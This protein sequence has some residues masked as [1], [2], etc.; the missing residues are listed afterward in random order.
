MVGG[1]LFYKNIFESVETVPETWDESETT[2][3]ALDAK[4]ELDILAEELYTLLRNNLSKLYQSAPSPLSTV[5]KSTEKSSYLD[6]LAK[7]VVSDTFNVAGFHESFLLTLLRAKTHYEPA[8]A[9]KSKSLG[10]LR[11]ELGSVENRLSFVQR[12]NERGQASHDELYFLQQKIG[13]LRVAISRKEIGKTTRVKVSSE[14]QLVSRGLKYLSESKYKMNVLMEKV[15]AIGSAKRVET[16]PT[17]VTLVAYKQQLAQA[18]ER[19]ERERAAAALAV[20][21]AAA[22]PK[23]PESDVFVKVVKK[24]T[25][26]TSGLSRTQLLRAALARK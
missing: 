4:T 22:A 23:K 13:V 2:S 8:A 6:W 26:T 9:A 24:T 21:Q 17:S 7:N 25:S 10:D 3:E 14:Y 16:A 1:V 12:M 5:A 11:A 15:R 18:A 20:A 19:A